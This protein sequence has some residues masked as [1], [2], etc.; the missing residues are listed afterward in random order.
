MPANTDLHNPEKGSIAVLVA[1]RCQYIGRKAQKWGVGALSTPCLSSLNQ[2]AI[3]F[4]R[5]RQAN[6]RKEG[7]YTTLLDL[8]IAAAFAFLHSRLWLCQS[9][10]WHSFPQYSRELQPVHCCNR[11]VAPKTPQPPHRCRA[12]ARVLTHIVPNGSSATGRPALPTCVA[13]SRTRALNIT[14]G[15]GIGSWEL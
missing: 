13:I 9:R 1:I 11:A 10:S 3:N 4:P 14:L 2:T 6:L 8:A 15:L 7:C 12:T 5:S